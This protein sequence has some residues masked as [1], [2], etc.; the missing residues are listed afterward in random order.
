MSDTESSTTWYH[1]P[2]WVL[3]LLF[4]V[5]GPF[6]LPFLW[7]SPRFTRVLKVLLTVAVVAY[8]G[9]LVVQTVRV[10]QAV[11]AEMRELD[12]GGD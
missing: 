4:V 8:T 3:I 9:L 1:R 6:G 12:L 11:Q 5:L 7:Q 10:V 2:V